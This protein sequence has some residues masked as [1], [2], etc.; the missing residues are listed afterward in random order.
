[1][2]REQ[3]FLILILFQ[4]EF[5]RPPGALIIRYIALIDIYLRWNRS[6]GRVIRRGSKAFVQRRGCH[7]ILAHRRHSQDQFDRPQHA[8]SRIHSVVNCISLYKWTHYVDRTP[9]RIDMIRSRLRIVLQNKDHRRCPHRAL[10]QMF[11][12]PSYRQVIIRDSRVGEYC[13]F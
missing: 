7:I 6:I 10:R 8:R 2:T 12:D 9:V 13:P 11:D 1:M 5:R 4:I 3:F